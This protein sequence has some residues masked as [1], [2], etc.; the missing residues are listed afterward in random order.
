METFLPSVGRKVAPDDDP[1]PEKYERRDGKE[2]DPT[3]EW[4]GTINK[5]AKNSMRRQFKSI[6]LSRTIDGLSV[7]KDDTDGLA[8]AGLFAFGNP[9]DLFALPSVRI[10]WFQ[11]R[12]LKKK[13]YDANGMECADPKKDLQ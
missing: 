2:N 5:S 7:D 4:D 11:K 9:F 12:R 13:I 1:D 6:Y 3:E 10:P 8:I